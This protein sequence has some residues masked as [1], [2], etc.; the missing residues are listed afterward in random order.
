VEEVS[1]PE[2]VTLYG[3]KVN[4]LRIRGKKEEFAGKKEIRL[5]YKVKNLWVAPEQGLRVEL[6]T[7]V[8]FVA[9]ERVGK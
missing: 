7:R 2:S 4:L 3:E 1:A 6:F 9:L 8:N 5:P